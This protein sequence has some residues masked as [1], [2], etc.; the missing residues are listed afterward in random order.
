MKTEVI[1][2]NGMYLARFKRWY[3]KKWRYIGNL[4]NWTDMGNINQYCMLGKK[5][6]AEE[7]LNLFK[8]IN[9]IK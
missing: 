1:E 2:V 3:H 5:E 8:L 9:N 4:Y 6:Y 7:R